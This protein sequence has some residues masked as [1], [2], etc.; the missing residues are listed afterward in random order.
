VDGDNL[1]IEHRYAEGQQNL[2]PDPAAELVRTKPDVIFA[3]GGDV[4]L[5]AKQATSNIVDPDCDG[6][7]RP[8]SPSGSGRFSRAARRKCHW[9]HV[10]VIRSRG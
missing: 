9:G 8:P 6:H 4:A 3:L 5:V 7:Q 10:P 1:V 2:L